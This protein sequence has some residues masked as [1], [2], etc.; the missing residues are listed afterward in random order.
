MRV[1]ISLNK[2]YA[3]RHLGVA[4]LFAVLGLWFGYDAVFVYPNLPPDAHHTSVSFQYS[5]FGLLLASSLVIAARVWRASRETL[6][7]NEKSMCGS[8]TRGRE[9]PFESVKIANS[10]L[11]QDKSI[12]RLATADGETFDVDG[13]H[14]TNVDKLF[15]RLEA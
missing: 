5:A 6:E 10:K 1:K 14:H 15:E 4:V 12:L 3:V 9:I 2:E 13:W 11:W 7:W 8:L